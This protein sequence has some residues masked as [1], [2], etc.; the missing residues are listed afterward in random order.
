[1]WVYRSVTFFPPGEKRVQ[2]T[3]WEVG[4]YAVP[5]G[6]EYGNKM[7]FFAVETCDDKDAARTAVHYLNG[8]NA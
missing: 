8:G 7:K 5:E 2:K 4:F 3:R 1:V 6:Q